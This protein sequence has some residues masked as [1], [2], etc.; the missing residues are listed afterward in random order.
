VYRR[1]ILVGS[2]AATRV[3][4]GFMFCARRDELATKRNRTDWTV[5]SASETKAEFARPARAAGAVLG[6]V[7]AVV[8]QYDLN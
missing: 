5:K 1:P 3:S 6:E 4:V 7:V 2:I 8:D